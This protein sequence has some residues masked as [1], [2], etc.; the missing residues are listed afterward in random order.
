MAFKNPVNYNDWWVATKIPM[1][2]GSTDVGYMLPND[3]MIHNAYKV[4]EGLSN[5]GYTELAIAAVIGN[6]QHE[7]TISPA[8]IQKWGVVPGYANS[9]NDVPNSVMLEYYDHNNHN[10]RG[11]GIGLIQWDSYTNTRPAGCTLVS[12]AIRYNMIWYDGDTQLF[13]LQRE[14]ETDNQYHY[15]TQ[16][17]YVGGRIWTWEDFKNITG[18]STDIAEEVWR[19]GRER[20]GD[21]SIPQRKRNTAWWLQYFIDNPTPSPTPPEPPEPQPV[22]GNIISFITKQRKKVGY[23]VKIKL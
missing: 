5:Q 12:F 16:N 9:L 21:D 11:Y 10:Q 23:N 13:R 3:Y 18:V 1:A 17:L 20:G 19:Q 8:G 6:M 7:S 15:W 22:Q 4:R 14:F 2:D